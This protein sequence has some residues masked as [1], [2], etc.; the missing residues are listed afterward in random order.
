MFNFDWNF[1]LDLKYFLVEQLQM[2]LMAI[3]NFIFI[4]K[5]YLFTICFIILIINLNFNIENCC[6]YLNFLII[7]F[8]EL[9]ENFTVN[10][11]AIRINYLDLHHQ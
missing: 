1:K 10:F 9:S 4:P 7:N 11:M 5:S 6:Y 3:I 8:L 2:Q